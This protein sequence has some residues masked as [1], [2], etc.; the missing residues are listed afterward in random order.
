MEGLFSQDINY[1][2][3]IVRGYRSGILTNSMYQ[4]LTQCET[5]EDLKMQLSTTDY[6][7]FLANVPS[8]LSTSTIA[9]KANEKLITEFKYLRSNAVEPLSTFLDYIT[10]S[11]MIDNVILLITG[12]LH[13]RDLND[14]LD[15]CHPLGMFETMPAL[16]VA[17]NV[18]ELYESVLVDTPLAP[19]FKG[20]LAAHDLDE[21]N[22]EIIRNT[23][24][25]RYLEDFNQFVSGLN[26]P[27]SEL[28]QSILGFEADRRAITVTINSFD[29]DLSKED[30]K[31]LYPT[32]GR[33]YPEGTYAL[34][35]ADDIETVKN[36]CEASANT[37]QCSI[38]SLP[39]RPAIKHLTI[40]SLK[41]K[42][43]STSRLSFNNS[44]LRSCTLGSSSKNKRCATSL[45]SPS[46]SHRIR[47]IGS[48][49]LSASCD[50]FEGSLGT[51][52]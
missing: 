37:L 16:C 44:T 7:N 25:K 36:A 5:L 27:T 17:T 20:C 18:Q 14:L 13:E 21:L 48:E 38:S 9:N 2:E 19:Y 40:S 49:S 34:S 46:V 32:F 28:M 29:T 50:F 8:P 6:Q 52:A 47:R 12:T 26:G 45:G 10:F 39:P 23:L 33:L 30:R 1:V 15:R 35:Q 4:N 24:Y 42:P 11:Y 3:G 41:R 22:I 43:S 51:V 31:S